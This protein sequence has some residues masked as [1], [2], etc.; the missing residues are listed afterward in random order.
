MC[1][2]KRVKSPNNTKIVKKGIPSMS[3]NELISFS[4]VYRLQVCPELQCGLVEAIEGR[5][6]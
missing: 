5:I 4:A 3:I 1:K 2:R 6:D